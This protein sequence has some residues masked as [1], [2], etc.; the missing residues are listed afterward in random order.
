M[1]SVAQTAAEIAVI[2]GYLSMCLWRLINIVERSL[3][4]SEDG[5]WPMESRENYGQGYGGMS[6]V[7]ERSPGLAS[8]HRCGL[9]S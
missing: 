7:V 6:K 9:R 2:S 1:G 5:P 3:G 4:E 8:V